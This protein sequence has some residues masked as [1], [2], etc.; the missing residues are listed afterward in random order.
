MHPSPNW[1]Q[2]AVDLPI[3]VSKIKSGDNVFIHGAAATPL[4]IIEGLCN[5]TDLENI[6]TYH[7]HLSGCSPLGK[8][9]APH[10][11]PV[12]FFQFIN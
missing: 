6:R 2:K 3:L 7:L 1:Q 12:S 5:R 4:S 8:A 10:I 9:S 11:R